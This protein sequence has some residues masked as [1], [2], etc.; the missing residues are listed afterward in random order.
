[1]PKPSD[2]FLGI[3]EFFAVLLPGALVTWMLWRWP[4]PITV[5]S[6]GPFRSIAKIA[7]SF[8]PRDSIPRWVA[9]AVVSSGSGRFSSP[10]HRLSTGRWIG[11]GI[12]NESTTGSL[13][14]LLIRP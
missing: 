3:I 12:A 10:P 7:V 14:T 8:L 6:S 1:M 5:E 9:F 2:V 4:W 13:P 11:C